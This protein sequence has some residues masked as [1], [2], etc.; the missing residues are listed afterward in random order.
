MTNHPIPSPHTHPHKTAHTAPSPTPLL[1][2]SK[3]IHVYE[4]NDRKF[5]LATFGMTLLVDQML[6]KEK[7]K[8]RDTFLTFFF[9]VTFGI[10]CDKFELWVRI[11]RLWNEGNENILKREVVFDVYFRHFIEVVFT[12]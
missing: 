9:D 12:S 10:F 2:D 5:I 3:S 8:E 11:C 1:H 6:K 4:I 7:K